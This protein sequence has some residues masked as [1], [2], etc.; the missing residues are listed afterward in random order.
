MIKYI[1]HKIV[2]FSTLDVLKI[3]IKFRMLM[4]LHVFQVILLHVFQDR[5]LFHDV[6]DDWIS[7]FFFCIY[8]HFSNTNIGQ[9]RVRLGQQV[10]FVCRTILIL[11]Y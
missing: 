4:I 1:L 2:S 3:M 6:M 9:S 5:N 10:D 8:L 7:I 11:I